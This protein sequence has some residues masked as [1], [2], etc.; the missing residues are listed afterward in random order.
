MEREGHWSTAFTESCK[1]GNGGRR[2]G[3]NWSSNKHR[4]CLAKLRGDEKKS[5]ERAKGLSSREE[6]RS[7]GRELTG[8]PRLSAAQRRAKPEET[9]PQTTSG[10]VARCA[11][12]ACRGSRSKACAEVTAHCAAHSSA[13]GAAHACASER[14]EGDEAAAVRFASNGRHEIES[15]QRCATVD[16]AILIQRPTTR[17]SFGVVRCC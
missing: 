1:G 16:R 2:S 17:A 10:A 14:E 5:R 9:L 4:G 13:H 8:G 6:R 3:M 11:L 12:I 15:A 7:N